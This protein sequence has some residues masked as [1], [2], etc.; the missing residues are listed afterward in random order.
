LT[1]EHNG[2]T[3]D[4][5]VGIY[6]VEAGFKRVGEFPSHGVGPHEAVL[7]GDG[8]TLAVANGGIATDPATGRENIDVAGMIPSLAFID[9]KNGDLRAQHLLPADLNRLSI[10]HLA[11][12]AR[13]EVWF[14]A[15][16]QGSLETAPE[17]IGYAT[18]DRAI[19]LLSPVAP[20]GAALK[21]Y[22]GS[23][24]MSGDGRLLAAS[25]PR[26]GC[27]VYIDTEARVLRSETALADGC[28]VAA[29]GGDLFALSSGHG[30][31]RLERA[32][33]APLSVATLEGT[34]LDNHLRVIG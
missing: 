6:D 21:G 25:A 17:L 10:R 22:I 32:G 34:E 12:N 4:G 33:Q 3:G 29:L 16:W 11:A 9:I 1:S 13:G 5:L 14:G 8:R 23:V 28:G 20:H 31:L 27:V 18:V 19:S 26:A 30:V 2:E 24:A 15:Q 7:L